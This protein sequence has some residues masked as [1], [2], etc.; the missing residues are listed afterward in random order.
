MKAINYNTFNVFAPY[1]EINNGLAD[2]VPQPYQ[3]K[4]L[5]DLVVRS[6]VKTL[7]FG[8]REDMKLQRKSFKST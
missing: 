5:H 7:V 1:L 2:L 4:P 6:S 3:S 8:T